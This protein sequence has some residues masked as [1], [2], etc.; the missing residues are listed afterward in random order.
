[1]G[2]VWA[3]HN[4]SIAAAAVR[5]TCGMT[6][7]HALHMGHWAIALLLQVQANDVD[8][9]GVVTNTKY[10]EYMFKAQAAFGASTGLSM[11]VTQPMRA[12]AA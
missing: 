2:G 7:C 8:M 1:M 3:T 5:A 6:P 4:V 11:E 9:Y 12:C 10:H